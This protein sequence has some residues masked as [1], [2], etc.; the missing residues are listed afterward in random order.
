MY[1]SGACLPLTNQD[2]V[3]LFRRSSLGVLALTALP[4]FAFR[5]K[6]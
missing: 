1:I 3:Q 2:T 5:D 4:I 6:K